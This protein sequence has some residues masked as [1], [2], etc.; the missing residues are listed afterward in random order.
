KSIVGIVI[1]TLVLGFGAGLAGAAEKGARPDLDKRMHAV[2]DTVK[3]RNLMREALK[4][5][6]VETG[7]PLGEVE[8]LHKHHEDTGPAGIL[9]ACTLADE[10]KKN[11]DSFIK[12]HVEG[13][14]WADIARDN[15]VPLEKLDRKLDNLEG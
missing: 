12:R 6:S 10:T 7:V 11:P 1:T 9:V 14:K 13:A 3:K 15:R 4:G 2:N 8:S 5:V